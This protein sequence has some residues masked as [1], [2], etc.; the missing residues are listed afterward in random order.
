MN[1]SLKLFIY[2]IAESIENIESFIEGISKESFSKDA[3]RQNAIVRKLEII[4][5]ATKNIPIPFRNKHPEVPWKE[6][7][8][9]RD[10]IVHS[11][12][13]INLDITWDIIKKDLPPLKKQINQIKKDLE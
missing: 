4:G 11:Y 2:D 9:L 1:R 7:A 12:F 10:K 13:D 3:L 8:G 5:E 6:I